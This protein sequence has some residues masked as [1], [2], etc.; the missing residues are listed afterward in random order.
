M[1]A[2][3]IQAFMQQVSGVPPRALEGKR[4]NAEPPKLP[5]F[6]LVS[7]CHDTQGAAPELAAQGLGQGEPITETQTE[8][9]SFKCNCFAPFSGSV[10]WQTLRLALKKMTNHDTCRDHLFFIV[11]SSLCSLPSMAFSG[12]L[13]LSLICSPSTP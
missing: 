12:S 7:A 13:S 5:Q 1:Q 8:S 2:G 6:L 10:G 11:F 4:E 3:D 9:D